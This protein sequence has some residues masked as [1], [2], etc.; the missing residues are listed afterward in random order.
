MPTLTVRV[1]EPSDWRVCRALRLAALTDSPQAFGSTL[2][3]EQA[4]TEDQWK[5]RLENRNQF[6]A[7][8][9]GEPC[10]LAGLFRSA[11]GTLELVSVWVRPAS[12]GRGVGDLL[13]SA[14]LDWAEAH[15]SGEVRLWVTEGNAAA[16]GLY[17]R[18][19]FRRTGAHR[20]AGNHPDEQE[21]AMLRPAQARTRAER[22]GR[23]GGQP[24]PRQ[25]R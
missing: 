3:R 19:G 24:R 25:S 2:S 23:A 6:V 17:A 1:L 8:E 5:R 13:L 4:L 16:E 11:P 20:A 14:A 7:H 10:G 9:D 21:F 12:R 15:G 22:N 18:H